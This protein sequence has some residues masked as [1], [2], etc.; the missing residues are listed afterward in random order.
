[1]QVWAQ[2]RVQ[3]RGRALEWAEKVA[4]AREPV[5]QPAQAWVDQ[6]APQTLAEAVQVREAE[7]DPSP[8]EVRAVL[9][10]QTGP[11]ADSCNGARR[12]KI[13]WES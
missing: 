11:V 13:S 6:C 8:D 3:G 12:T 2:A 1:M 5:A 10:V 7:L 9:E 4:Q